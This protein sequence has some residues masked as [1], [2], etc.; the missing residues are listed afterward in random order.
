M[1]L[2]FIVAISDNGV[3]GKD[4]KIPWYVRGEQARFK[5]ITM[6]KPI[7]MGRKTHESIGKTLPGRLNVVISTNADYKVAEGS[8]LVHSLD[9]ALNLPDVANAEEMLIIGGSRL[10]EEAMPR[11]DRLYLTLVHTHVDGD[12][13]FKY[14]PSEWKLISSELHKKDEVPDRPFD[15]EIRLLERL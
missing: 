11:A 12:T 4:G 5:E 9:E 7:I 13:F 2:S 8:V 3:I 10:I 1:I 14:D 15:F 6:G